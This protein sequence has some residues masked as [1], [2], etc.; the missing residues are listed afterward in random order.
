MS[1]I[2]LILIVSIISLTIQRKPIIGIYPN[3]EPV[4]AK[5]NN[6]DAVIGS[7][8]RWLESFGAEVMVIHPWYSESEIVEILEKINGVLYQGGS[9]NFTESGEWEQKGVMITKYALKNNLPLWGTC[10]GFQ[11]ISVAISGNFSLLEDYDDW[12]LLHESIENNQTKSAK[13]FKG[14]SEKDFDIYSKENSTIYFHHFGVSPEGFLNSKKLRE[15]FT[16]TSLGKDIYNKEF[17]NSFEGK[18][19]SIFAVQYH[20]EKVPYLRYKNYPV[21]QT[22]P[23]LYMSHKIG[24]QFIRTVLEN[25]NRM[26]EEERKKYDF[27]NTI[28]P[29]ETE[30]VFDSETNTY[31]YTKK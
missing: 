31:Y 10:Q 7:Y 17:V 1:K 19:S 12:E 24:I 3:P 14:F 21:E 30:A 29:Q 13:M 27:V 6:K 20:P 18:N 15:A 5:V 8:V 16:I 28:A 25:K 22:F 26:S 9:R 23:C 2:I 4:N 11:F